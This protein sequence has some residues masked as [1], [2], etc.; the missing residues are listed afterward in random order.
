MNIVPE[1]VMPLIEDRISRLSKLE[2]NVQF[3]E[4]YYRYIAFM[5]YT[6]DSLFCGTFISAYTPIDKPLSKVF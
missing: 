5:V 2:R 6:L 4:H 3:R 1:N